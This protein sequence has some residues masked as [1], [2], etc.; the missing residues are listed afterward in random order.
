M[1]EG[2]KVKVTWSLWPQESEAHGNYIIYLKSHSLQRKQQNQDYNTGLLTPKEV[3]FIIQ[4]QSPKKKGAFFSPFPMTVMSRASLTLYSRQMPRE[5]ARRER[6]AVRP[7]DSAYCRY[8]M[9]ICYVKMRP[10]GRCGLSPL[11]VSTWD[12]IPSIWALLGLLK[13]DCDNL[14]PLSVWLPGMT[15]RE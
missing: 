2:A 8:S 12:R 10:E 11:V 13:S 15:S 4:I 14:Y 7:S 1:S 3:L 5:A 9:D 6:V